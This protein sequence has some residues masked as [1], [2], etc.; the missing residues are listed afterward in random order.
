M[1]VTRSQSRFLREHNESELRFGLTL[2][3]H[4]G[5]SSIYPVST[6][7]VHPVLL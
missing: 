4:V 5:L 6:P 1:L 7:L 2:R 3:Y